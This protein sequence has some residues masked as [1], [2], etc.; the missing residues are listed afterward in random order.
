MTPGRSAT[1]RRIWADHPGGL[2]SQGLTACRGFRRDDDDAW[3][4]HFLDR[5]QR[6]GRLQVG[7][8]GSQIVGGR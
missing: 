5:C 6:A 4:P 1:R 2:M 3:R 7:W 8:D